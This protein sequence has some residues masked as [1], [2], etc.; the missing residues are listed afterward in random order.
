M[1]LQKV[2]EERLRETGLCL[3]FLVCVDIRAAY[4]WMVDLCVCVCVCGVEE[5]FAL[6]QLVL[7]DSVF[8]SC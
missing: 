4:L 3:C 5:A 7:W 1:H 6:Q 8:L 2:S